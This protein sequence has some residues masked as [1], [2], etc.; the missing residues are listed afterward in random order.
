MAILNTIYWCPSE[1]DTE[2]PSP[3]VTLPGHLQLVGRVEQA[4]LKPPPTWTE[5]K[6]GLDNFQAAVTGRPLTGEIVAAVINNDPDI[7]QMLALAATE[8]LPNREGV[9]ETVHNAVHSALAESY[10][11]VAAAHY[12]EIARR[13]DDVAKQFTKLANVDVEASAD[14]ILATD[15]RHLEMWEQ[16]PAVS[17]EL[18]QLLPA[19]SAAAMLVRRY[20]QPAKLGNSA[21]TFEIPLTCDTEG[22]HV[23]QVWLAW[24]QQIEREAPSGE[25]MT[26]SLTGLSQPD[27]ENV[28]HRCGRWSGLL[29][30]GAHLAAHPS[31]TRL[32]LFP[33]PQNRQIAISDS[34]GRRLP[35]PVLVDPE[36]A[37]VRPSRF[38]RLVGAL[39][40]T[41][42]PDVDLRGT[43][44]DADEV[45]HAD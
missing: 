41:P 19:L 28:A 31:P 16:A 11:Q 32:E 21:S 13:F 10:S 34:S 17:A 24:H 33:R 37:T 30:A 38:A 45:P 22:C 4:G 6:H 43:I 1:V 44:L 40:R 20:D 35:R 29:A 15:R 8:T 5:I 2:Q 23:R 3:A 25:G 36:D 7:P 27:I 39:R 42:E 12:R 14:A 9:I 18:D 26:L